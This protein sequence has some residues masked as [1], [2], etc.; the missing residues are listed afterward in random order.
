MANDPLRQLLRSIGKLGEKAGGTLTDAQLLERFVRSRDPA[1]FEL[2]V[3]RHGPMVWGVCRRLLSH[4]QDA[5]DAFQA[6]FLALARGTTKIGERGAVAA[7]LYRVALYTSLAA[8]KA[9]RRRAGREWL[10][11]EPPERAS[12]DCPA[13]AASARDLRRLID[14]EVNRLPEKL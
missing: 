9:R 7:W 6:T 4:T 1:A 2:L 13:Q 5:E 11:P 3:W 14:E 10:T 8:R 12:G